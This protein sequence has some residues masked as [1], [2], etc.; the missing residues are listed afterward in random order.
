MREVL[1][2]EEIGALLG[3]DQDNVRSR[4]S[5]GRRDVKQ[6][7]LKEYRFTAAGRSSDQRVWGVLLAGPKIENLPVG[8]A[9]PE[10]KT[11]IGPTWLLIHLP[12]L[13]Y[14]RQIDKLPLR[15]GDSHHHLPR[16][17][18]HISD[19]EAVGRKQ[20]ISS[21]LR[22]ARKQAVR[23][24]QTNQCRVRGQTLPDHASL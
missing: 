4:W 22:I 15:P 8:L 13:P 7:V 17:R 18:Q 24:L 16:F 9:A 19:L 2:L 21:M 6:E 10:H 12:Q 3:V 20:L 11:A 5:V 1:Q 14:A 23:P